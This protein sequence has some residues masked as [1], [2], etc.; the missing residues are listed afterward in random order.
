MTATPST[1]TAGA[2]AARTAYETLEPFH[3]FSY[4]NP[5]LKAAQTDTGL[6]PHAFY[7][8][9]RGAP[10]ASTSPHLVVATFYNFR[11]D[12]VVGAWERSLAAGLDAVTARRDTMLDDSL[13]EILGDRFSDDEL[14]GL[15]DEYSA[16]GES[17]SFSGR[18]LAAAWRDAAVPDS[19]RVALWYRI[20]VLREWRGDNHIAALVINGLD[21]IDAVVFHEAEHPDPTI[22]RRLLGRR[23][24]QLT[25]GWSDEEWDAS[26]AR[27]VDR[28]L[29][30]TTD[31]GHALT[32]AGARLH[33]EIEAA[34][35]AASAPAWSGD[36]VDDLLSRT[37][38][39]VKA[40][41][42]AGVLPGTRKKD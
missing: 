12:L 7:V 16:L 14:S 33:D 5:R 15:A 30:E 6:D 9:A 22:R 28:G 42:D 37:R 32:D 8:G 23:L 4:F 27:L 35:D 1:D 34:T 29:V 36:G 25:R 11:P 19:P 26:V 24:V 2:A 18:P 40:I 10:L 41:I 3:V 21:A 38:P 20:A 39:V 31:S 17:L 13:A